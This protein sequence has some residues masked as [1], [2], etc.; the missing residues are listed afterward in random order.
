MKNRLKIIKE[1]IA[2]PIFWIINVLVLMAGNITTIFDIYSFFTGKDVET[3]KKGVLQSPFLFYMR[4]HWYWIILF[5][6]SLA[7]FEGLYRKTKKFLGETIPVSLNIEEHKNPDA[8]IFDRQ[9]GKLIGST[10]ELNVFVT[11]RE[12][13][14][15]SCSASFILF[16]HTDKSGIKRDILK[17]VNPSNLALS[18]N[19][20]VDT[21]KVAI[22]KNSLK[23]TIN[24]V[25]SKYPHN[26]LCFFNNSVLIPADEG[27]YEF[28]IALDGD[29]SGTPIERIIYKDYFTVSKR[30]V[31][32]G[33]DGIF[34]GDPLV[35][36]DEQPIRGW[37][38]GIEFVRFGF[39]KLD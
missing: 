32:T 28:E 23:G 29:I 33:D 24:I 13:V 36:P 1:I 9:S 7:I 3:F 12:K 10:T 8:K 2:Q 18:W 27:T 5:L 39:V 21:K 25:S 14:D 22:G 19:G 4:I 6:F 20:D 34:P 16:T 11:N 37:K 15:I 17:K 26:I 31:E 38:G 35:H 30:I